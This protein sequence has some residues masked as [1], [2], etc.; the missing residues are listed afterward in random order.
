MRFNV[1]L[2]SASCHTFNTLLMGLKPEFLFE[3]CATANQWGLKSIHESY[4]AEGDKASPLVLAYSHFEST[5]SYDYLGIF[6]S[7]K[8]KGRREKCVSPDSKPSTP[9]RV[10]SKIITKRF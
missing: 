6:I 9:W 3:S 10:P 7:H 1:L 2:K 5:P 8:S 4:S